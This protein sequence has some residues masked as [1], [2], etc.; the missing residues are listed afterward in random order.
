MSAS[1]I[2]SVIATFYNCSDVAPTCVDSLLAQTFD[3]YEI[4]LVDDG[5]RDGTPRILDSYANRPGVLVVHKPN[6]GAADARNVGMRAASGAYLTFVDGDDLVGPRHLEYLYQTLV[7]SGAGMATIGHLVLS[8][9]DAAH[10]SWSDADTWSLFVGRDAVSEL[11]YERIYE[12]PWA[13]LAPRSLIT[14]VVRLFRT[15]WQDGY[16]CFL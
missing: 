13:K 5:S 6:G 9:A 11:L 12:A 7:H 1:P 4:V 2:V 10:P 3:S 8:E 16:R 15:I 14:Y